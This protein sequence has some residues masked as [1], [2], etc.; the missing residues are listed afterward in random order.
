MWCAVDGRWAG[1]QDLR[2]QI[3]GLLGV[4]N[5]LNSIYLENFERCW[6][7]DLNFFNICIFLD[8]NGLHG[9]TEWFIKL[10]LISN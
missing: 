3:C 7:F 10:K 4:V 6:A 2:K 9:M 1:I 5:N 8:I